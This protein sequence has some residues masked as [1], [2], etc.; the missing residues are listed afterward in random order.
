M[1]ANITWIALHSSRQFGQFERS[2][3]VIVIIIT[4]II[5]TI[6]VNGT[7]VISLI[8]SSF[9]AARSLSYKMAIMV[10]VVTQMYK[11]YYYFP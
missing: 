2:R 3:L 6:V 5:N 7:L 8:T 10:L 11:N 4:I 1:V 9:H